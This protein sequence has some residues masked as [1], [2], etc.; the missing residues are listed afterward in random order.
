MPTWGEVIGGGAAVICVWSVIIG[1]RIRLDH[2][3][4]G[5]R[6][7]EWYKRSAEEW[8]GRR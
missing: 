2:D 8:E 4:E 3:R 7:R 6:E 5:R 1:W